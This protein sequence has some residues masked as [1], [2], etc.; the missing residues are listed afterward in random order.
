[1]GGGA[2]TYAITGCAGY[3]GTRLTRWLLAADP[4]HR[5]L[6]FDVRPPAVTDPRLEFHRLDV[7]DPGLAARLDG[8]AV[9][10]LVH[11]AF[12]LDPLYDER[13]MT[14][15][16]VGGT[17]NVL[18]AARA[19][20][21]P[22]LV[23]TSSTTAYGA[24]AD[25]PVPLTEDHPLRASAG[26]RYAHDKRVMDAL[27][28]EF[29]AAHREVR[30]CTIRP[31]IVLGPNVANYIAT[32]L[33]T[34]PVGALLD[35]ADPPLQF[36]HEDDLTRLVAVCL[37]RGA[38]GVFNAVGAGTLRLREAAAAQRKPAL[39]LPAAPVYAL[40]WAAWKLRVTEYALPPGVLD[41]FR[42]PWVASGAKAAAELGF[43]P[44]HDTAACLAGLVARKDAV[45]ATFRARMRARGRR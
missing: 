1:V 35:G 20:G 43:T 16:D 14:D 40:A 22:H 36:M 11:L 12:V 30:V 32:L 27:L 26:F 17:R 5:V 2:A 37:A 44:A 18:A 28:Q 13:E 15:I 9:Q 45:L 21:I 42:H 19:A 33:L 4:R 38:R 8:R 34:L 29:Q 23:A 10:A 24:R 39:R 7:R 6:G 41:F 3:L 31:C 25:N